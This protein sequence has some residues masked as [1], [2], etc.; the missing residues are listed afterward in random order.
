MDR[1]NEPLPLKPDSVVPPTFYLGAKLKKH[2][3]QKSG[4]E[5]WGLSATKY[6]R[7]A[8]K[9]CE[10]YVWS[11]LPD[12]FLVKRAENPFPVDYSPDE[13]VSALGPRRG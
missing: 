2:T 10:T 13:D 12:Y 4:R 3:F 1:I 9:N 8:V 5:A 7:E 11:N 6:V